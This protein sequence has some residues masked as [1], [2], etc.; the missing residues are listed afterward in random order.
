M[1]LKN[2]GVSVALNHICSILGI[3]IELIQCSYLQDV[4]EYEEYAVK[5][6]FNHSSLRR[7]ASVPV[8]ALSQV[9]KGK[10]V[11]G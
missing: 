10:W 9:L 8:L 6:L 11:E 4:D 3:T 1:I 7:S 5:E 2:H